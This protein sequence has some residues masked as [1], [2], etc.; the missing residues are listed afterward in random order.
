LR[1]LLLANVIRFEL[2]HET[3][4]EHKKMDKL[5]WTESQT[6]PHEW[7][8]RYS[9]WFFERKSRMQVEIIMNANREWRKIQII[10]IL[11]PTYTHTHPL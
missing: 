5:W 2:L 3:Q 8:M 11:S 7:Y 4:L 6:V 10:P 1:N 9:V